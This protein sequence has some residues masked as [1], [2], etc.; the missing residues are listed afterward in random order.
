[1]DVENQK[2]IEELQNNIKKSVMLLLESDDTF[3][4]SIEVVDLEHDHSTVYWNIK[5]YDN[6]E[7]AGL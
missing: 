4:K 3:I 2:E 6:R 5:V 1:M 7:D